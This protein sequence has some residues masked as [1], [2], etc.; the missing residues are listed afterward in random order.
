MESASVEGTEIYLTAML[1]CG[2]GAVS[3]YGGLSIGGSGHSSFY[4][5]FFASTG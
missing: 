3:M 5:S 1:F 2:S 4:N